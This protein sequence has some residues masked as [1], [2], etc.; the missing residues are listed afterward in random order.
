MLEEQTFALV[1][2][3]ARLANWCIICTAIQFISITSTEQRAHM[4]KSS[5]DHCERTI[6]FTVSIFAKGQINGECVLRNVESWESWSFPDTL[7]IVLGRFF[8]FWCCCVTACKNPVATRNH[9]ACS[10]SESERVEHQTTF[11]MLEEQTFALVQCLASVAN[12]SD[13]RAAIQLISITSTEAR[14]H[15]QVSASDNCERTILFTVSIFAKGQINGECVLWNVESWKK[16]SFPDTSNPVLGRFFGFWCC[17]CYRL[18][19]ITLPFPV[20]SEDVQSIEYTLPRGKNK[21]LP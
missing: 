1:Q 12:W 4:Q 11:A 2:C 10:R 15:M 6:L 5:N 14:A 8:G 7:N 13:I 17:Y 3:L 19:G 18:P 9:V 20:P 21:H 16:W